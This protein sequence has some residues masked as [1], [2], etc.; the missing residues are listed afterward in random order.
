MKITLQIILVLLLSVIHV[1]AQ[2]TPFPGIELA[3][4]EYEIGGITVSGASYSDENALKIVSGLKVGSKIRVPGED[5]GNAIRA[6]W[7]LKLFDKIEISKEKTLGEVL[8]INIKVTERP[9]ISKHSF[10]GV[11]K[12]S[13]ED[14]NKIVERFLPKGTM[15]TENS[16]NNVAYGI[17]NYWREKGY[18]DTEVKVIEETD[19]SL[20]NSAKVLFAIDRHK[21][22]K[23]Q[24]ITF[25]GNKSAK[26][27][28]LRKLLENTKRRRKLFASSKFIKKDYEADKEKIIQYYNTIGMRDARIISDSIWRGKNGHL[29]I[30]MKIEE[31]NR[32]YF[33][34]I[35]WKGNSIHNTETLNK[36]LGITKGEVFNQELLDNRLRFSQDGRDIS[37][38]YLDNGYLFFQVDPQERVIGNDSIDLDIKIY[39]GPQAT[40][41]RVIIK[42]NDRT[43][44]HVIR[45]E[46]YT[47]PGDKFS[48]QDIIRSQRQIAALGYF[49][50]E[51]LGVNPITNP[52]KKTVDIEYTVEEKPS[53]QLE[54]SAGW[55]G[56]GRGVIGTLGVSF[57]NFS[58]HNILKKESWN[59]LP[60]G[61]GQRLSLRAQSNGK[62]FQS[63]NASFTEPWL[64]GKKPMS[65]TVGGFLTNLTNGQDKSS[66]SYSN[67]K[68]INGTVGLG[69]RLKWPDDNFILNTELNI[70][71]L[72]LTNYAVPLSNGLIID[73]GKFNNWSLRFTL[74]RNSIGDPTF[75]REGSQIEFIGQF[76]PPYSLFN[77]S[78]NYADEPADKKYKLLEYHKWR[79]NAV[80]YTTIVQN[81]VFKASAKIGLLGHYNNKIGTSP[82][83][84]F[85]LGGDGLSGSNAFFNGN[86]LIA[87]RGYDVSQLPA[88]NSGGGAAFDKFTLEL[89]YPISLNPSSTIYV[90]SF[91]EGGNS[92]ASIRDFNPFDLKKS[93][94]LGVRVFLPVFGTI[95]FDY[96]LGFDKPEIKKGSG[97]AQYG[98]FSI[99]LGFEPD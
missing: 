51:T 53:D 67:L 24:N 22:V 77:P 6:L 38:L 18:L 63:Y 99:I 79:V 34:N 16:K 49:N 43:N 33:R 96:G 60:Q 65:F 92:W 5:L 66:T 97:L 81:L 1:Q 62:Y 21:K 61:D 68:I 42:G 27:S 82:F 46:L 59:P 54:L 29:N 3:P 40:I 57:N 23:I 74:A 95:G 70:Q 72:Q 75:P 50:P 20:L 7:K 15:I 35:S 8:F 32:Y 86:D 93:A 31:G 2:V 37:S 13:H 76:T 44:E 19:D 39:E 4:G 11:K 58:I 28:K 52:V 85:V 55:G 48:R 45:R 41:D 64:G 12:G 83:E 17:K 10:S 25:E 71:S 73:N 47:R 84:R 36:V 87:L 69:T 90:L 26:S 30:H 98:R 78:R 9:R 56:A 94:G 89:R 14:L 91:L 80:W 88:S